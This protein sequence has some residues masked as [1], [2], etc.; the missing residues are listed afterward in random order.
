MKYWKAFILRSLI[1]GSEGCCKISKG[2]KSTCEK[3]DIK[4]E[5]KMSNKAEVLNKTNTSD[6]STINE[7]SKGRGNTPNH[8]TSDEKKYLKCCEVNGEDITSIKQFTPVFEEISDDDKAFEH[9]ME[10]IILKLSNVET[11]TDANE[12]C[13]K[14]FPV[15][16]QR[17][18]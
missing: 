10:D 5:S 6:T 14:T 8:L 13:R 4:H 11:M 17:V 12:F 7:L 9:C 15:K 1:E 18:E 2:S 16:M 3:Q